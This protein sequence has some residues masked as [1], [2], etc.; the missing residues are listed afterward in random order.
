MGRSKG[1]VSLK[2]RYMHLESWKKSSS[3]TC[4]L[5]LSPTL[6]IE[7]F[8]IN[9][10]LYANKLIVNSVAFQYIV[11]CFLY[12]H[13]LSSSKNFTESAVLYYSQTLIIRTSIIRTIRLSGLFSLDPIFSWI[14]IS[15]DCHKQPNNP[16]KRLLKQHIILYAFLDKE[17]F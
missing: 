4:M 12:L 1:K 13:V 16:F 6:S 17:L 3:S 9:F 15:C 10:Y 11:D 8:F 5:F 7:P 14:L 2:I